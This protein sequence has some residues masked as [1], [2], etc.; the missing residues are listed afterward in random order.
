MREKCQYKILVRGMAA[1]TRI[2]RG[3]F[4]AQRMIGNRT[5]GEHFCA[6]AKN[7][8]CTSLSIEDWGGRMGIVSTIKTLREMTGK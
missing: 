4:F 3:K 5:A 2:L 1:R 7:K 6:G 8:L